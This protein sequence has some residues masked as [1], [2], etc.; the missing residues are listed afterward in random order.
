VQTTVIIA[1]PHGAVSGVLNISGTV[2]V[3]HGNV[4]FIGRSRVGH[5]RWRGGYY[6]YIEGRVFRAG[7]LVNDRYVHFVAALALCFGIVV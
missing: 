7:G 3:K 2:A 6:W 1:N 4:V 5:S